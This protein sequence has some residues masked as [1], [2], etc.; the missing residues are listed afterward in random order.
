MFEKIYI[1]FLY[2]YIYNSHITKILEN[3]SVAR[4]KAAQTE[5]TSDLTSENETH[6]RKNKKKRLCEY[7]Y[8]LDS[9]PNIANSSLKKRKIMDIN[10]N[11]ENTSENSEESEEIEFQF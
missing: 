11:E 7:T 8:D 5:E 3:L 9:D 10:E 1:I 2:N 4:S 6:K